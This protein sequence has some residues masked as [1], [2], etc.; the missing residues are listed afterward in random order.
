M[1]ILTLDTSSPAGSLAFLRDESVIGI[2]GTS[3]REIYSSRVFRHL[4]FLLSELALRLEDFDLYAAAAG[5]GS[6]TGLRVG[7]A[8]VK[9]WAEVF[10]KP[11]AA[12]SGL[13]AIAAQSRSKAEAVVSAMDARRNELYWG[14]YARRESGDAARFVLEGDER[15][16]PRAEFVRAVAER[17]RGEEQLSIA[18]P[19][20]ELLSTLVPEIHSVLRR[21]QKIIVERVSPFLAP[22]I[23]RL[24]WIRA[25]EGKLADS[26][27][28]DANYIR[29]SDAE[30]H[31]KGPA[32]S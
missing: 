29:R 25:R 27:T 2:I 31:W 15:A 30:L 6:F 28:L 4:E 14:V 23:G 17:A 13:E 18:T 24:G 16:G 19:A 10:G 22:A 8:A 20:P 11:I 5:P 12:I 21:E 9:G 3:S 32:G 1:L 7:L 26:L